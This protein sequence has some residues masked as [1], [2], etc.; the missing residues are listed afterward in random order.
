MV[1]SCLDPGEVLGLGH[2][3]EA[4]TGQRVGLVIEVERLVVAHRVPGVLD[5]REDEDAPEAE[6]PD[7]EL[8]QVDLSA[9]LLLP[10]LRPSPSAL[11]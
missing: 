3:R 5:A 4:E 7:G 9:R 6:R 1:G 10:D 8:V 2:G 11:V